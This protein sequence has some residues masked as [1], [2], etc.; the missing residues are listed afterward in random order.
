MAHTNM[1]TCGKVNEDPCLLWFIHIWNAAQKEEQ[2][3]FHFEWMNVIQRSPAGAQHNTGCSFPPVLLLR[4]HAKK[5][6]KDIMPSV[7]YAIHLEL[8]SMGAGSGTAG[9][10]TVILQKKEWHN[11]KHRKSNMVITLAVLLKI[12]SKKCVS[13]WIIHENLHFQSMPIEL[14][15]A[16]FYILQ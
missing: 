6:N 10:N 5:D 8:Y 12:R 11:M 16:F 13:H 1:K 4:P 14:K 15:S 7:M 9:E 2:L 3:S